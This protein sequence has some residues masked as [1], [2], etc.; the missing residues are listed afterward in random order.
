MSGTAENQNDDLGYWTNKWIWI[1]ERNQS[2]GKELLISEVGN[3]KCKD[4]LTERWHVYRNR[5]KKGQYGWALQA[6]RRVSGDEVG[7]QAQASSHRNFNPHARKAT[8]GD[9]RQLT[10]PYHL[11]TKK[12]TLVTMQVKNR[13]TQL[14]YK[15]CSPVAERGSRNR[16]RDIQKVS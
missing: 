10:N 4:L 2:R 8:G 7:R 16:S 14:H 13:N 15:S 6:R 11:W 1:A 9:S 5:K 3:S 12:A